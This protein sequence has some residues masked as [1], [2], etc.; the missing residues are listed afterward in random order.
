V[1]FYRENPVEKT[2]GGGGVTVDLKLSSTCLFQCRNVV[3]CDRIASIYVCLAV[4]PK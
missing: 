3:E 4:L 2:F 1:V